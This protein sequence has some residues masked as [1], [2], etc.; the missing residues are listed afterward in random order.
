MTE[1]SKSDGMPP[2]LSEIELPRFSRNFMAFPRQK[3]PYP[4]A[5][6]EL[7]VALLRVPSAGVEPATKRLEG[8]C[9]IR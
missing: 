7:E 2:Q 9:S 5:T 1:Y 8:S 4:T 3:T 6:H